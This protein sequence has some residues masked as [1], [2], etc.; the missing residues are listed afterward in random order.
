MTGIDAI[1]S[2]LHP[3]ASIRVFVFS[4]SCVFLPFVQVSLDYS[5][6]NPDLDDCIFI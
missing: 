3:E 2:H 6:G 1:E 4:P 5:G